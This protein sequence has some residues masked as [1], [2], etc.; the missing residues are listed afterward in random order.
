MIKIKN[1]WNRLH[2]SRSRPS[3]TGLPRAPLRD[4]ALELAPGERLPARSSPAGSASASR[5][6]D[7][8]CVGSRGEGLAVSLP[9]RG[10]SGAA[11]RRGARGDPGASARSRDLP[12]GSAPS[13]HGQAL[14]EMTSAREMERAFRAGDLDRTSFVLVA[15]RRVLP[16]RGS[17]EARADAADQRVRVERYVLTLCRDPEA[18][19]DLRR[20]P[21]H[22][23]RP[24]G[25]ATARPPRR[26]R[27]T[28]SAGCWRSPA[29]ARQCRGQ[30]RLMSFLL[31][32]AAAPPGG[33]V[34]LHGRGHH[35]PGELPDAATADGLSLLQSG[36]SRASSANG[37]ATAR[38][39]GVVHR[40]ARHAHE[41]GPLRR[42]P[43]ER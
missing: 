21:G 4:R 27:A 6:C 8:P 14:A 3:R 17:A 39:R 32:P 43:A 28:R 1:G 29:H 24:A 34:H 33:R 22:C 36:T 10:S 25:P 9:R 19:A 30:D 37:G 15:P 11:L 5:R 40:R 20:G 38:L 42:G 26:P 2:R 7:T 35:P 18:F 12:R 16:L 13:D 23:S 31:C 41:R